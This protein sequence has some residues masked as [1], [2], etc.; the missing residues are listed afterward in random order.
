MVPLGALVLICRRDALVALRASDGAPAWTRPMVPTTLAALD[1]NSALVSDRTS[2]YLLDGTG[3]V[4]ATWVTQQADLDASP[5]PV[6]SLQTGEA[7]LVQ[8]TVG[9][10]WRPS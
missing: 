7:L 5:Q 9:Y 2:L 1:A 4:R 6:L 8:G 10:R 3:A